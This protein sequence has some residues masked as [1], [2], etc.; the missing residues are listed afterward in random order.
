MVEE[1]ADRVRGLE[2]VERVL[3]QRIRTR[4]GDV[5][6]WIAGTEDRP[7][8]A[9]DADVD[10]N[11]VRGRDGEQRGREHHEKRDRS[12]HESSFREGFES[13]PTAEVF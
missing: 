4:R 8:L 13:V 2:R 10:A 12:K 11:R 7:G 3:G 6:D 5:E 9:L 1:L